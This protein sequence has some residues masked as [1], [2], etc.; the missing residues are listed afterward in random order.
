MVTDGKWNQD[1]SAGEPS[2]SGDQ[3]SGHDWSGKSTGQSFEAESGIED[4]SHEV[5]DPFKGQSMSGSE[6][7]TEIPPFGAP[8]SHSESSE[9]TESEW[10]QG[11]AVTHIH[12]ALGSAAGATDKNFKNTH[13]AD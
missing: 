8:G 13:Q 6:T 3:F 1:V 12:T 7:V 11:G 2:T 9:L 10:D 5:G 4:L